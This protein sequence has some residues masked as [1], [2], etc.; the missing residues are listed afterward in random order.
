MTRRR[1]RAR[2][3]RQCKWHPHSA[4]TL[5]TLVDSASARQ[6][7][8]NHPPHC[9]REPE[10]SP[11]HAALP[12]AS[13]LPQAGAQSA[14]GSDAR[15]HAPPPLSRS[16]AAPPSSCEGAG[17]RCCRRMACAG[18]AARRRRSSDDAGALPTALPC[19][20]LPR[21]DA[22]PSPVIP[23]L[24]PSL[25]LAPLPKKSTCAA[26][27]RPRPHP[28]ATRPWLLRAVCADHRLAGAS[29]LC[30]AAPPR[31]PA[32][33]LSRPARP[34]LPC[35]VFSKATTP[36]PPCRRGCPS[37]VWGF[38]PRPPH[39]STPTPKVPKV[40]SCCPPF[41]A[42]P[43]PRCGGARGGVDVDPAPC[44]PSFPHP[45]GALTP[46]VTMVACHQ[47]GHSVSQLRRGRGGQGRA[48]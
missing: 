20:V 35:D 16:A 36:R 44:V 45:Q 30:L 31:T 8:L 2:G 13:R 37:C 48:C 29:P 18:A 6:R 22:P 26:R 42:H 25:P 3:S 39:R 9:A 4:S 23:C 14:P 21:R 41:L 12:G 15:T 5:A 28:A 47:R 10:P 43:S 34:H 24:S 7:A 27:A 19:F 40:P 17:A 32:P 1:A 46:S 11:I 38:P 33:R